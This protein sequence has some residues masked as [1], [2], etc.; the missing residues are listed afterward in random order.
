L[1]KTLDLLHLH[2]NLWDNID[3][4]KMLKLSHTLIRCYYVSIKD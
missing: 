2:K 4:T 3:I 1:L